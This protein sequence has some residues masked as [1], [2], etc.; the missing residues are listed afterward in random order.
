MRR[1]EKKAVWRVSI[2]VFFWRFADDHGNCT[3]RH[4]VRYLS[5]VR[6]GN[7]TLRLKAE[8]GM[9]NWLLPVIV[10]GVS[11]VG[12]VFA[13]DRGR[14]KV[15]SFFDR[16]SQAQDPLGEFNKALDQQLANIQE[17]LDQLSEAL[18]G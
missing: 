18:E 9:R 16:V 14:K 2:S 13:S 1:E 10:L 8:F 7:R 12:L 3:N 17:T 4:V 11:G 6:A 5:S 15:H